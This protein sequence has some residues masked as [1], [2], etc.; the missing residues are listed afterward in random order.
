VRGPA[1]SC[2]VRRAKPMSLEIRTTSRMSVLTFM[3]F[4]HVCV[5]TTLRRRSKFL[6]WALGTTVSKETRAE[7]RSPIHSPAIDV[8]LLYTSGRE[9]RSSTFA[10]A[11]GALYALFRSAA[12]M[13]LPFSG[14]SART[15]VA[16]TFN[17]WFHWNQHTFHQFGLQRVRLSD[18]AVRGT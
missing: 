10:E 17:L 13:T 15:K 7:G 1:A 2:S 4:A 5:V 8:F 18:G 16:D 12:S 9:G 11:C 6:L 3:A 14:P